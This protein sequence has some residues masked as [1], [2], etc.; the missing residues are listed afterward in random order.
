MCLLFCLF[1]WL[2]CSNAS[3]TDASIVILP[4]PK[5]M[6]SGASEKRQNLRGMHCTALHRLK[7]MFVVRWFANLFVR[8]SISLME[9]VW[10]PSLSPSF[11]VA[12][13][14]FPLLIILLT[15]SLLVTATRTII[16]GFSAVCYSEYEAAIVMVILSGFV[17]IFFCYCLFFSRSLFSGLNSRGE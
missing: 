16:K 9:A 15:S 7:W 13:A 8:S 12:R 1:V 11:G 5:S 4:S 14:R 17:A 2:F 3:L 6:Q 10:L